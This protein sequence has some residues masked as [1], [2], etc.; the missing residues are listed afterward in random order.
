[1]KRIKPEKLVQMRA[2]KFGKMGYWKE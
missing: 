2:E 1:L